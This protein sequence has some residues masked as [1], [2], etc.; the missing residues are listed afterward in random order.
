[1]SDRANVLVRLR[2]WK[3]GAARYVIGSFAVAYLSVGVAPCALATTQATHDM[4]ATSPE[5]VGV[6]HEHHAHGVGVATHESLPAP[7]DHGRA[8]CPHC[9][10]GAHGDD[11]ACFALEG[12]TNVASSHAKDTPQPVAPA[13]VAAVLTL[14]PLPAAPWPPPPLCVARVTSV[15]LNVWHCIFLI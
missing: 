9:P 12:L 4:H 2:R 7:A 5:R 10:P 8:H 13:L 3:C 15:P 1:M 11:A 14:P 6:V